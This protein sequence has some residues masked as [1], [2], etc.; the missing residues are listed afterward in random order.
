MGAAIQTA[1]I[2]VLWDL[3]SS[4]PTEWNHIL[5]RH[6]KEEGVV[7]EKLA[8]AFTE[9]FTNLKIK[10]RVEILTLSNSSTMVA[11]LRTLFRS[12]QC[13]NVNLTILESRP[14]FEGVT[15]AQTLL[16]H[17][18]PNVSMELAT[19][20]SAAYFAS[21]ADY[22][23]L[24]ADQIDPK[25]G[26]VK[27]KIGSLA[28]AKFRHGKAICVTSTDKIEPR[29]D[30]DVEEND[31]KEVTEKWP[32]KVKDVRVRNVYFEWVEGELIDLYITE[33]GVLSH[34]ELSEIAGER[35]EL[36]KVWV[37]LD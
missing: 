19:D 10:R 11:A 27:N 31:P 23:L 30:A 25:T 7:L 22:I 3:Q 32:L 4:D 21:K 28:A 37:V 33:E 18:N 12:P 8:K 29:D 6:I 5:E 1:I 13:P 20:A 14:L 2:R 15:L 36:F 35:E 16:P 24:G 17:K 26:S 9:Y 34:K